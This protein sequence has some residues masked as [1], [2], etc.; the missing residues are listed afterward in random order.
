MKN[1]FIKLDLQN[2][3]QNLMSIKRIKFEMIVKL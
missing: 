1:D 3:M 2:S